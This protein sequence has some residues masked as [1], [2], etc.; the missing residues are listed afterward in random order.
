MIRSYLVPKVGDGTPKAN[1]YRPA[2]LNIIGALWHAVDFGMEPMMLV[3]CDLD[4]DRHAILSAQPDVVV[5][6][7]DGERAGLGLAA[8]LEARKIPA[9]WVTSETTGADA[10]AMLGRCA[11]LANKLQGAGF[12]L[13]PEGKG[14]DSRLSSMAPRER[15]GLRAAVV[16]LRKDAS[17]ISDGMTMREALMSVMTQAEP[18]KGRERANGLRL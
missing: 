5:M 4:E 18:A 16:D 14:L 7:A 13:F 15:Q 11:D 2:Y 9:T 12:R 1:P 8:A 6:P 17:G 3:T 10:K